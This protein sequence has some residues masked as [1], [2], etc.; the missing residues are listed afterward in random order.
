MVTILLLQPVFCLRSW[1]T[2]KLFAIIITHCFQ[3]KA[4]TTKTNVI[5]NVDFE[6]EKMGYE[7]WMDGRDPY[8]VPIVFP[9][10]AAI[11]LT[12]ITQ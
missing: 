2:G 8:F 6:E 5:E 9:S 7:K 11:S 10:A 1:A 3:S 4:K 12:L